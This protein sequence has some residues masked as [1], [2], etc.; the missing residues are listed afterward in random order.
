[1]S[2]PTPLFSHICDFPDVYEPAEDTFVLLDALESEKKF[3]QQLN[4]TIAVEVG[5]GSGVVMAFLGSIL[6]NNTLYLCTDKNPNAALCTQKT[7]QVNSQT[8]DVVVTDLATCML[9]KM[10]KLVDM[11]IFN[12]PYVPS[13]PEETKSCNISAAWAGGI[14]GRQVMDRFFSLVPKLLS[15]KGVF[16]LVT[17]QANKVR[18]IEQYFSDIGFSAVPVLS[19]RCGLEHLIVYK[20]SRK[21]LWTSLFIGDG[22]L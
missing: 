17:I 20:I 15:Q 7:S 21:K 13:L 4:P 22:I 18:E 2:I 10:E 6:Q 19:R 3:I 1:M 11:L 14:D 12:P 5:C 8:I 9:P 16:Y